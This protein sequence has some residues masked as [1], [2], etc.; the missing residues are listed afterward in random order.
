[1]PLTCHVPFTTTVGNHESFYNWSAF[2]NRYTMPSGGDGNFWFSYDFEGVHFASVSTEHDYAVG[3]AQ[4]RWLNEDLKRASAPAQRARVPSIIVVGYRP[5][6]GPMYCSDTSENTAHIAGA[7][8]QS[9]IE[10]LLLQAKVDVMMTG[11]E[12]GCAAH[13]Y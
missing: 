1:M 4:W 10:P 12:H 13:Q 7:P 8:F 2:K 6:P 9:A 3:S 11:H 5:M